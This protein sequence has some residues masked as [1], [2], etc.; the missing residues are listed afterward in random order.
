[1][2]GQCLLAKENQLA[3]RCGPALCRGGGSRPLRRANGHLEIKRREGG[4]VGVVGV[5]EAAFMGA[6]RWGRGDSFVKFA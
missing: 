3:R 5:P 4:V 2:K 1:M 6:H